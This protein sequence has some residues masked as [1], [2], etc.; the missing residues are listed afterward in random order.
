[1]PGATTLCLH[2]SGIVRDMDSHALTSSEKRRPPSGWRQRLRQGAAQWPG[3]EPLRGRREEGKDV[4]DA[5]GGMAKAGLG[6]IFSF[7]VRAASALIAFLM[8]V[9][10]ARWL[11]A[12]EFGIYTYVWVM[13]NVVGTLA[14]TGLAMSAVRFLNE[15][16]THARP[17]YARGYLRFGRQVSAGVGALFAL[18]IIAALWLA[19][20]IIE[21]DFRLPLTIG[22]LSLP[23]FALT[24]F[25]DGTGRARSWLGLAIVPPYILRP[26]L[27]LLLVGLGL[28]FLDRHDAVLAASAFAIS[29]WIVALVQYILQERRFRAELGPVRPLM[30]R[31]EWLRV[32]L[33]LLLLDSFNLL[34]MNVDILLLKLF[35]TPDQ[36]GIYFAAARIISFIAFVHFAMMTVATPRFATAYAR[37]DIATA[38]RLLRT[39]RLWTLAPAVLG[40]GLLLLTGPF[41][42]ALF[43]EG[44]TA[45]MPVMTVLAVGHL[46]NTLTGPSEAL[47]AVSG[48]QV[49]IASLTG[50]AAGLNIVLNLALIPVYGLQGAAI[51]T[52]CAYIFRGIMLWWAGNRLLRNGYDGISPSRGNLAATGGS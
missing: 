19:P 3:P 25:H 2:S 40:T 51:A 33:P 21:A 1:M 35:V 6:A 48:K 38:A 15:Y 14:V 44:F 9:L 39:F 52:S 20:D 47:L 22:M 45:A 42:L 26:L 36:L 16:R 13:V 7:G 23:A 31:G 8:S 32:A 46:I 18:L 12:H 11:G 4:D 17:D 37:R 30:R 50:M 24:D 10:M 29:T 34:M 41:I 49:F 5:H 27:I 43:G 28:I